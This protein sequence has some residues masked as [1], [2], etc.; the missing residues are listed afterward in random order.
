MSTHQLHW[1]FGEA[2]MAAEAQSVFV[3]FVHNIAKVL[4]NWSAFLIITAV[5]NFNRNT[6]GCFK[7][8]CRQPKHFSGAQEVESNAT[9]IT[10]R[11]INIW[12]K[13]TSV[14]RVQSPVLHSKC[15]FKEEKSQRRTFRDLLPIIEFT[16]SRGTLP[17]FI[18][19]AHTLVHIKDTKQTHAIKRT[20]RHTLSRSDSP[21]HVVTHDLWERRL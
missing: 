21:T 12:L 2:A 5:N 15:I 14:N 16:S 7:G 4:S 10:I 13:P 6:S 20:Q 17:P 1:Q 3:I 9:F 8:R 11:L 18:T 19:H